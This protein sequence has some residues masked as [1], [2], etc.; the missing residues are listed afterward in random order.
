MRYSNYERPLTFFDIL[1]SIFRYKWRVLCVSF[2]VLCLCV[3]GIFL[4]PKKYESEAKLFVR[5]GRGSASLDPATIGQTISIQESREAE[6]NSIVDMLESRGLAERIVSKIG[7]ERILKKYAWAEVQ[8]ETWS[9]YA[10]EMAQDNIPALVDNPS[11]EGGLTSDQIKERKEYELAV[12]ELASN[13]KIDSPKKSNT[14]EV[15]YRARTPELAFDV[16]T[17][18]VESYQRMHIEA[19]QSGD[20]LDFFDEQFDAQKRMVNEAEEALRLAKNRNAVVTVEGKQ[21]SLQT[22]IT[23]IKKLELETKADLNAAEA[24]VAELRSEWRQLPREMMSEKTLGIARN[25]TDSMRDRLYQL[26]I[27]ERDLAAKYVSTHPELVKIR[28]QL[29]N[30]RQIVNSQPQQREQSVIAVNPV[31]MDLE[32]EMHLAEAEVARLSAKVAAIA[33][34]ESGLLERLEEVNNLE[35]EAFEMQRLIDIARRN[36]DNYAQKLEESRINAALDREAVSNVSVVGEPTIRYKHASPK[37]SILGLLAVILS[38]FSGISVAL[39]SDYS[40]NAREMRHIRDAERKRYLEELEREKEVRTIT[41][42]EHV[43]DPDEQL[44]DEDASDTSQLKKAK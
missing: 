35:V 44:S 16:V 9:D 3:V 23:E 10:I 17:A 13:L 1:G 31:R 2:L 15:V 24:K 36:H 11:E 30:A 29:R 4:F 8:L 7:Y 21:A 37:R 40:A 26:E 20:A 25:D 34:L 19:Y 43:T 14:I 28:E 38:A 32:K 27:E 5:L 22:Q 42:G 39:A 33:S 41:A 18:V 6:M 12:K